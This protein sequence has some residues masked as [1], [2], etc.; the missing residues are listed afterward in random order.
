MSENQKRA[1]LL[2][3]AVR[4]VQVDGDLTLTST[5]RVHRELGGTPHPVPSPFNTCSR[6][7]LHDHIN[8]HLHFSSKPVY[9]CVSYLGHYQAASLNTRPPPK[10]AA[11]DG[12]LLPDVCPYIY[13]IWS[14]YTFI[15]VI[16]YSI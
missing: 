7:I 2:C 11:E 8:Q 3:G 9:E 14:K 6:K 12:P 16:M 15:N 1:N 10:M 13:E 4:M 5:E